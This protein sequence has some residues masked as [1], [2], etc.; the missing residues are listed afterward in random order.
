[1]EVLVQNLADDLND[2]VGDE[3]N[4]TL[5]P[6]LQRVRRVVEP[7]ERHSVL[8]HV[9]TC[10]ADHL[11]DGRLVQEGMC[12]HDDV[13][14]ALGS[15]FGEGDIQDVLAVEVR[16]AATVDIG[17][18]TLV[19][20]GH[21]VI[22]GG[23]GDLPLRDDNRLLSCEVSI[24]EHHE[25]CLTVEIFGQLLVDR[26]GFDGVLAKRKPNN[27]KWRDEWHDDSFSQGAPLG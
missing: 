16:L 17:G 18:V 13:G 9:E 27:A 14:D 6:P 20:D 11:L 22:G 23:L 21:V 15:P 26:V 19:D 1:M 10:L 12:D 3:A 25:F 24:Y 2:Q 7:G 4:R 5:A 8:D